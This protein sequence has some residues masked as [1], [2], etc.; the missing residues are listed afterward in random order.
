MDIAVQYAL[1]IITHAPDPLPDHLTI[2]LDA[3]RDDTYSTLNTSGERLKYG[4]TPRSK[5]RQCKPPAPFHASYTLSRIV[6]AAPAIG[7]WGGGRP[8]CPCHRCRRPS[9]AHT[10][11][12]SHVER[13]PRPGGVP[14]SS[15]ACRVVPY[16][17]PHVSVDDR[18]TQIAGYGH[19]QSP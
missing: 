15:L 19:K 16:L 13:H 5:L 6:G 11:T 9:S 3:D 4:D 17:P 7:A 10:H 2:S 12:H 18:H 8:P 1:H 14:L